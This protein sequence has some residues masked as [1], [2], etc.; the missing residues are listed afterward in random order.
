LIKIKT[1]FSG[2]ISTG[3]Y[4]NEKPFFEIEE[5]ISNAIENCFVSSDD[6]IKVRQQQLAAICYNAF[7]DHE[8]RS[9]VARIN[10]EREDIRFY[11]AANGQQYPS[12]TSII[13]WD[14]DFFIP[15][16]ELAQYA[17]KGKIVHKQCEVFIKTGEWKDPMKIPECYPDLVILKKGNLKLSLENYNFQDFLKKYPID[18]ASTETS[19]YN[20]ILMYAGTQDS[21]GKFKEQEKPVKDV[22]YGKVTLFDIK[23]TGTLDKNKGFKQLTAYAHCE[24]NEDVEQL[25]LIHLNASNESGYAK[26][27]IE[28]DVNKFWP[29]FQKDREDFKKR[30]GI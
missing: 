30:F 23:T 29:L 9:I 22:I 12:V 4:E 28:T 6:F 7:K 25:C 13:N 21:K 14:A 2:V 5:E 27:A 17:S 16:H 1:G 20:N 18:F 15:P 26:P 3:S 11:T 19:V 8:R 24:G 10:K